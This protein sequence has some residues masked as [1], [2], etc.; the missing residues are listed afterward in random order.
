MPWLY[1][2]GDKAAESLVNKIVEQEQKIPFNN[3]VTLIILA[4]EEEFEAFSDVNRI[5]FIPNDT[6]Y[7]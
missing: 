3:V 2:Q 4:T 5:Q 6:H 1:K 7:G